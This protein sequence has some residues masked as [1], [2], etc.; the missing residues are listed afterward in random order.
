MQTIVSLEEQNTDLHSQVDRLGQ[1]AITVEDLKAENERLNTCERCQ[2]GE[3]KCKRNTQENVHC[4]IEIPETATA[5]TAQVS[6]ILPPLRPTAPLA[7]PLTS[8]ETRT[9]ESGDIP[10]LG[11]ILGGYPRTGPVGKKF[12]EADPEP[13]ESLS[14]F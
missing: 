5:P 1:L 2:F 9:L 12:T 6:N 8:S 10:V 11:S 14:Q 3:H 7:S 13:P 4:I